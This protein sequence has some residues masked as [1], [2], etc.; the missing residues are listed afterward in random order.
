MELD[1]SIDVVHARV[2]PICQGSTEPEELGMAIAKAIVSTL[3]E[4]GLEDS[5]LKPVFAIFLIS[6]GIVPTRAISGPG[7]VVIIG[8]RLAAQ[9][10]GDLI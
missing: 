7:M 5:F 8:N 4:C 6:S 3:G 1:P 10:Q 9:T 2:V